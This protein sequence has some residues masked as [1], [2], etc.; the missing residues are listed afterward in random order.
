MAKFK[1]S[2]T[3]DKQ[4]LLLQLRSQ[5]ALL[6][7]NVII[8]IHNKDM[9]EQIVK[10]LEYKVPGLAYPPGVSA[11]VIPANLPFNSDAEKAEYIKTLRT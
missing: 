1:L 11:L 7:N 8:A 10:H 6:A 4:S 2:R 3:R 5:C 9:E